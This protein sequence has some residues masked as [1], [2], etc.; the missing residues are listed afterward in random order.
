MRK[1]KGRRAQAALPAVGWWGP[2]GLHV[3]GAGAGPTAE[4]LEALTRKY[5][6]QLR[7][8]S[9][10]AALVERVGLEG[11]E[12]LLLECRVTGYAGGEGDGGTRSDAS[13]DL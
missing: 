5:R 4:E 8:S 12:R 13:G 2:E 9:L 11:A 7:R 3:V 10:W 1:R 6:E